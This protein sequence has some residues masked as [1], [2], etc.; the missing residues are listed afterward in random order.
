MGVQDI[1]TEFIRRKR[2]LAVV[3]DEYGGT[4]GILTMEDI[5]EELIG[6]IE[7]EHD[8]EALVEMELGPGHYRFSARCEVDDLNA[9][10]DS[11]LPEDEAYET[12]GGLVLSLTE[13]IPP[14]G[15][16]LELDGMS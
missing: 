12:L 15:H 8:N 10:F 5:M 13:E 11:Q 4:S 6:D 9:R 3:V 16:R 14:A 1:L 2:H 7:D